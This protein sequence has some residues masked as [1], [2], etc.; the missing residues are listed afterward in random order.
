MSNVPLISIVTV[1]Y[2]SESTIEATF[3]SIAEQTYSNIEYI[4]VDGEST[5]KTIKLIEKYEELFK[6]RNILF[7][8]ISEKDQ[9]IYDAM[10]KGIKMAN[11][12]LI[13][14]INS[15]DYYEKRAVEDIVIEYNKDNSYDVYHGLL[16]YYNSGKLSMIR[17]SHSD[18]LKKHMIEH[19][20]C[21]VTKHAYKRYGLFNLKYRYVADYELLYRIYKG[22]GQFKLLNT[23]IAHFFD[24]GF[25]DSKSSIKEAL[26]FKKQ[27][28]LI[29]TIQFYFQHLKLKIKR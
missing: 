9:G 6:K 12:E 16:C 14:I 24:G 29:N 1:C 10:N 27:E 11:G 19:P 7:R 17:G 23:V 21:F 5:D 2:N 13:G 26:L 18:V 3:N 28:G 25:G 22:G 15:D 20:A 4:V 8:W